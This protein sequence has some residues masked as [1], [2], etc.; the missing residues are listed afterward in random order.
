MKKIYLT[1]IALIGLLSAQNVGIGTA[2]PDASAKLD[3]VSTSGGI[4]IPRVNIQSATDATTIPTPATGLMVWNTGATFGTA[5]FYFNSGTTVSPTWVRV[6]DSSSSLNDADAD[7]NNEI[8]DLSLSG[9]TL[10]LS[11]DATTVNLAPYLDNTDDQKIDIFSL[12]G[13]TLQ[14][15]LESDGEATKTVDLSGFK[16]H[17][18]YEIGQTRG[19]DNIADNIFT[20]GRV[21]LNGTA[22]AS[23]TAGTGVLE[24]A[25]SL[26]LD[27]N[28]IITNSNTILYLQNDNN[29]DLRVDGSTLVV[30]ASTNRVGIGTTA[31]AQKLSVFPDQNESAE[32]GR[33]HIGYMGHNDWA[34]FSHI[35]MNGTGTYALLQNSTG[36]TLLNSASGQT[37][38]FRNNNS[39]QFEMQTDGDLSMLGDNT[40][41]MKNNVVYVKNTG[42]YS[43]NSTSNSYFDVTGY[44]GYLQVET[45]DII[46]VEANWNARLEGGSGNDDFYIRV[47]GD[48]V[49]CADRNFITSGWIRPDESGGNHDNMKSMSYMD[50]WV[51]NCT[52]TMRFR[53]QISNTGDD[54]W[55]A[56]D[57]VLFVT[58]Y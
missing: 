43:P 20:N 16:D 22:D 28:E 6:L 2:S 58:K 4:L 41:H 23:G 29:G 24:I 8:Q 44:T 36:N 15:S 30:D 1:L 51:A 11:G 32:I 45:G 7:P 13:N 37:I 57:I 42:T 3:I 27:G 10:S 48:G 19:A 9:N 55:E 46:K 5:G 17:N 56:Q 53:L 54:D 26:R 52:G 31:P 35:D 18:F 14:L 40:I 34:G 12:S 47:F 38:G 25:N 50:Y 33:A 49:T 21:Q 39:T